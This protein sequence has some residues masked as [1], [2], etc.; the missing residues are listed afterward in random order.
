[1]KCL[2]AKRQS[3][4]FR[5]VCAAPFFAGC[6]PPGAPRTAPPVGRPARVAQAAERKWIRRR[7]AI[8]GRAGP[9]SARRMS[10]A[11]VASRLALSRE[12]RLA[13]RAA[14]CGRARTWQSA[15]HRL[16][17][18]ARDCERTSRRQPARRG[19]RAS[20]EPGRPT[21]G[22]SR[23]TGRPEE[24]DALSPF[25]RL[26]F[27]AL[28]RAI[29]E[30]S[31]DERVTPDFDARPDGDV[32]AEPARGPTSFTGWEIRCGARFSSRAKKWLFKSDGIGRLRPY[33]TMCG[34]SGSAAGTAGGAALLGARRSRRPCGI[35][36]V[37]TLLQRSDGCVT[38][39]NDAQDGGA[40]A[41]AL[42]RRAPR[43]RR[44]R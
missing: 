10:G 12:Q 39:G 25:A 22:H 1:M 9:R 37:R 16:S 42:R 13:E 31:E 30:R 2:Q 23:R 19:H 5:G 6:R 21:P 38:F 33:A 3:I 35:F 27:S 41:G 18:R 28:V 44:R 8:S 26:P 14:R 20:G 36:V 17:G 15:R 34:F 7:A 40:V 24:E 43:R 11:L 29:A 32:A 4:S